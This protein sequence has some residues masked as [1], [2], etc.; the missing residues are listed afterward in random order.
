[1][2]KWKAPARSAPLAKL[3]ADAAAEAERQRMMREQ[4]LRLQNEEQLAKVRNHV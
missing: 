4:L 1:M 3:D 2:L